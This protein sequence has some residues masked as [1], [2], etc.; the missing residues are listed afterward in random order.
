MIYELRTHTIRPGCEQ[1]V[2]DATKLHIEIFGD[3]CGRLE[4]C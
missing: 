1:S 2:A 3:S 4:G